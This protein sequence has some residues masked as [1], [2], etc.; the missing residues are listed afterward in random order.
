MQINVIQIQDNTK[1]FASILNRFLSNVKLMHWYTHN[2]DMHKT[3]ES[4]YSDMGDM[5]DSLQEEI[6]GTSKDEHSCNTFPSFEKE[7]IKDE[8]YLNYS[9]DSTILNHYFSIQKSLKDILCSLEFKSYA[10]SSQSGIMNIK[11]EIISRLNK[12]NYLLSM[13]K[14]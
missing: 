12:T 13:I 8:D 10:D 5:F 4:L 3:F 14:L 1:S 7:S 2:Y 11:D 6:I 9:E